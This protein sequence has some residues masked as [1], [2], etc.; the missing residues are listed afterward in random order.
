MLPND[1][2]PCY[3]NGGTSSSRP[4]FFSR[5]GP[6]LIIIRDFNSP[7]DCSLEQVGSSGTRQ[8]RPFPALETPP[9]HPST[10]PS[11]RVFTLSVADRGERFPC[12]S[13][14]FFRSRD[15]SDSAKTCVRGAPVHSA[16]PGLRTAP[17]SPIRRQCVEMLRSEAAH[18]NF[19][20]LFET[21]REPDLIS[22]KFIAKG[23]RPD[24]NQRFQSGQRKMFAAIDDADTRRIP[25]P[26]KESCTLP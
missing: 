17:I 8:A 22:P 21:L 14:G 16:E 20:I 3:L 18:P 26:S 9:P 6:I 12:P 4:T 24:M 5:V 13:P 25:S 19:G 11:L 7:R 2:V 15:A 10:N 23:R 1:R